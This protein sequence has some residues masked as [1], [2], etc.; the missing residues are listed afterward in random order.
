MYIG[1]FNEPILLFGG[2]YSNLDALMALKEYAE[3]YNIN[4]TNI[5]CTGDIVAYCGQPYETVELI[6]EWG[7]HVLMGN[8]EESFAANADDCGCGFDSGTS[9]DLLSIEWYSFANQRLSSEQRQ[10]FSTLPRKI[11]FNVLEK[12]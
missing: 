7:I 8:C 9:C 3:K 2:A 6:R 4:P 5:I 12:K 10:W 11:S 1:N